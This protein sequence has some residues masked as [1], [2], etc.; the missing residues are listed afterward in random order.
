MASEGEDADLV[1]STDSV[2]IR[3]TF[4]VYGSIYVALFTTFCYARRRYN[5]Y[6]NLKSWVPEMQDELAVEQT[7]KYEGSWVSW[8]WKVFSVSDDDI[9]ESCGMDALCFLRAL[10]MGVKLCGFGVFNSVWLIPT[11]LTAEESEET[12]YLSDTFV[13][14]SVANLPT[15]SPRFAAPVLAAYLTVLYALK[16]VHKEYGWYIEYRHKFM[17]QRTPRNYTVYVSA[18]PAQ[19]R[20]DFGLAHYFSQNAAWDSAKVVVESH[21]AMDIPSLEAKVARRLV[22]VEKLE[23][24]LALKQI[25]GISTKQRTLNVPLVDALEKKTHLF[26]KTNGRSILRTDAHDDEI[27]P[28]PTRRERQRGKTGDKSSSKMS[29]LEAVES[30]TAFKNELQ[31]LNTEISTVIHH[32]RASQKTASDNLARKSRMMRARSTRASQPLRMMLVDTS[33]GDSSF[34]QDD[35]ANQQ[36]KQVEIQEE[37]EY[38]VDGATEMHLDNAVLPSPMFYESATRSEEIVSFMDMG[39]D[40]PLFAMHEDESEIDEDS[41]Y[42]TAEYMS[43]EEPLQLNDGDEQNATSSFSDLNN[44]EATSVS[45]DVAISDRILN[46]ATGTDDEDV[47][48]LPDLNRAESV[49]VMRELMRSRSSGELLEV[50]K[51]LTGILGSE[52]KAAQESSGSDIF[53]S[54]RQFSVGSFG[55][56]RSRRRLNR[57]DHGSAHSRVSSVAQMT[58]AASATQKAVGKVLGKSAGVARNIAVTSGNTVK[59]STKNAISTGGKVVASTTGHM[60]NT[61]KQVGSNVE[62]GGNILK[63]SAAAIAPILRRTGN[64]VPRNAGFVTFRDL[65]AVHASLQMVQ[66]AS[67]NKMV[68]DPAPAPSDIFW[69]NIGLPDKAKKTGT[70][71]SSAA[72]AILCFFWSIPT[73]FLSSLTELNSLKE[74]FPALGRFV[75][76][77]PLF[78]NALALIAP[79]LLLI[80]NEAILPF[81]LESFSKWEGHIGIPS[82]QS[83]VFNKLATFMLIQTFFVSTITGSVSAELTNILDNPEE[84]ITLLANSLPAQSSYFIQISFVFTFAVHGIEL[85]RALPLGLAFGRKFAGPNLTAKQRKKKYLFLDSLEDPR[86]F[87]HA[88]TTAQLV[89]F[90]VVFFVYAPI[91]PITCVFL[92]ACFLICESGY[93]YN[94]IHNHKKRPDSGGKIWKGLINVYFI[95]IFIGILTLMGYLVLRNT[96]YAIPA[97]VPL[98]IVV[99]LYIIFVVPKKLHVANHLPTQLCVEA[100]RKNAR[101]SETDL[102]FVKDKYLQPA[103]RDPVLYPNDPEIEYYDTID[104]YERENDDDK[105]DIEKSLGTQPANAVENV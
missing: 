13:L 42:S 50:E 32:I 88:E 20:S 85:I 1:K 58:A 96:L 73:T 11:F 46:S 30:I 80:L 2:I 76:K 43:V 6:F 16:L 5:K 4:M 105:D 104:E 49:S 78:E 102:G 25:K 59:K 37:P 17:Q 92:M 45:D 14:M 3:E 68:I 72:T 10:R 55:S 21:I 91:A 84:I 57:P 48:S 12:A 26:I 69:P 99:L 51:S 66:Y 24:A 90:Y 65:Y 61:L 60:A 82:L 86:E 39:G 75:E 22:V 15:D 103:L 18:V 28:S 33:F 41:D 70:L 19:F 63:E 34:H 23:H 36:Q 44:M 95:S 87:R 77:N 93:R 29:I 40:I 79:L 31:A 71:L 64:R 101:D 27:I 7:K 74:S 83:A 98:L 38:I 97:L 100:D 8:S 94:F 53:A 54:T 89:L 47:K 67:S 81:I 56:N 62:K 52:K 35:I 9:L